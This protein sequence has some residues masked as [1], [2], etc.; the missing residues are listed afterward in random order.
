MKNDLE[1]KWNSVQKM[2]FKR[3]GEKLDEQTIL[4][5]IGLQELGKGEADY[6]K[7]EKLDIIH[8]GVCTALIPFG[9]YQSIGKDDDGWP[10]FK[11]IKKLPNEIQGEAQESLLKQAIIKHFNF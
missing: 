10:H 8:I 7:E 1:E 4:F 2:V 9:Y 5:I 11:N 3:F 6:K